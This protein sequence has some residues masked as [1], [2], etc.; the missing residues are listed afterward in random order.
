MDKSLPKLNVLSILYK[1]PDTNPLYI[2]IHP[3]WIRADLL[4][5]N[6]VTSETTMEALYLVAEF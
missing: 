4:S 5:V 1:P 6:L 3:E 2:T